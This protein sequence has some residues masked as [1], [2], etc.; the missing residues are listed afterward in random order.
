MPKRFQKKPVEIRA[1]QFR[2]LND[3]NAII[4]WCDGKATYN[5]VDKEIYIETLEGKMTA[6]VGSWIIQGVEGEFY[7]CAPSIFEKT[8]V[9]VD[10]SEK[11]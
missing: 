10:E 2:T 9:P 6:P 1:H 4:F 11:V 5:P 8:Y 3:A 7:P